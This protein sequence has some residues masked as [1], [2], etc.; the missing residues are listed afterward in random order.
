MQQGFYF[1]GVGLPLLFWYSGI[2]LMLWFAARTGQK[3]FVW[4]ISVLGVAILALVIAD[5]FFGCA[6][7]PGMSEA[8]QAA[9]CEA[10]IS[11]LLQLSVYV[12]APLA[13]LGQALLTWWMLDRAGRA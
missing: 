10:P 7:E 11:P 4:L 1:Y 6:P 12:T 13:L 3:K 2:G 8:A 5:V 9:L